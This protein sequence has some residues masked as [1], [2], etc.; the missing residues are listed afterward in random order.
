MKL[1]KR[2]D[3]NVYYMTG[4]NGAVGVVMRPETH[5]V[6]AVYSLGTTDELRDLRIGWSLSIPESVVDMALATTIRI[7]VEA[8]DRGDI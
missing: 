1:C 3:S 6:D 4:Y 7:L 2:S 8:Y 5:Q